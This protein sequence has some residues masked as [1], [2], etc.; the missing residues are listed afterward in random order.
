MSCQ[1]GAVYLVIGVGLAACSATKTRIFP[2]PKRKR[3]FGFSPLAFGEGVKLE[4]D[5]YR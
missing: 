3:D 4:L 2:T 5:P 1:Q